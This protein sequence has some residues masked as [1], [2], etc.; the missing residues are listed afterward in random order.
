MDATSLSLLAR[1]SRTGDAESWKRLVDLYTPLIKIWLR[2]YE[3]QEADVDDLVQEVLT[4]VAQELPKFD[5]NQR[6]GAFRKWMRKI[7]VH[8]LQNFWRSQDY[9]PLVPGGTSMLERLNQLE[10]DTDP[11]SRLWENEHE[12][13][14]ISRLMEMIRPSFHPKTWEAFHRQIFQGQKPELVARELGM[15]IGSVYMARNR[16]LNALRREASGLVDSI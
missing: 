5:H 15:G 6:T 2:A 8:R 12:Q 11:I 3:V 14:V 7:L 4:V 16:V 1:A 10:D 13:L 9:R